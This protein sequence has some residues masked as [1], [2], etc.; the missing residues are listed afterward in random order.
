[1]HWFRRWRR[2][3][4]LTPAQRERLVQY[5]G[6]PACT[7]DIDFS[8]LPVL[9][10]DVETTGLNP[11]RD[12]LISIGALSLVDGVIHLNSEFSVVLK[13]PEAS[14]TANILVHGIDGSTQRN[15]CDPVEALLAFL[16]YAGKSCIVGFHADF[17]RVVINRAC[18]E[19]LG[20]EPVNRWL[21]LAYLAP[22]VCL[23]PEERRSPEGLDAWLQRYGISNFSR[24]SAVSDALA[25]AQLLLVVLAEARARGLRRI[26]QLVELEKAQRWLRHS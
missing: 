15:G 5:E 22:A 7:A 20:M 11:H 17:D 25:T 9:I 24:H 23:S 12:R 19:Y 13:Q 2:E 18:R 4:A 6:L 26:D 3:P 8:E 10:A 1:M 21:D 14:D 16:A